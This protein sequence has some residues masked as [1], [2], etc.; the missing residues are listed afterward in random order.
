[1][2]DSTSYSL[3][4]LAFEMELEGDFLHSPHECVM[5]SAWTESEAMVARNSTGWACDSD[6]DDSEDS[7]SVTALF[8]AP[9]ACTS[10]GPQS[11]QCVVDATFHMELGGGLHQAKHHGRTEDVE[12]RFVSGLDL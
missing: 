10:S 7:A 3:S 9:A 8:N 2:D 4:D 6:S 5:H 11:F 12:H 1:M